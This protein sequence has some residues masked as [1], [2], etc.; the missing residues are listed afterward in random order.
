[1]K[2][3]SALLDSYAWVEFFLGSSKGEKVVHYVESGDSSTPLIVIAELSAKYA[4]LPLTLWNERLEFVQDKTEIL[5]LTLEIASGAG[6]TRQKMREERPHFGLADA[7][8]YETAR[9]H[10][11][12]VLSG[13][14]H[15]KGLPHAIFLE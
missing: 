5:P 11:L 12:S 8:I 14:P 7:I 4:S 15:F 13:D 6:R 1:M 3:S 9:L 10:H 2:T